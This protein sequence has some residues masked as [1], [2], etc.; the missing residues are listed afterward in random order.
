MLLGQEGFRWDSDIVGLVTEKVV[1]DKRM[2]R[3]E[4]YHR[5]RTALDLDNENNSLSYDEKCDVVRLFCSHRDALALDAED[6]GDVP[7]MSISIDTGDA[8]PIKQ[9]CRPLPPHL[10][11]P[12]RE[13]IRKWLSS[14][15]ISPSQGPWASPI[16][17]VR[18]KNGGWRFAVD[19]RALNLI[20][21]K[22]AR[23]I[24]NLNSKLT[25]LRSTP[26]K[27]YKY[28]ATLDLS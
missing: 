18:K 3:K 21:K 1:V 28:W 11:E 19:Y 7:G 8:K 17:P 15:V 10:L 4:F 20:T 2:T 26:E 24:A 6:V 16:V 23:P 25:N 5:I 13:Q 22:D 14:K 27:P 12:L 9:R